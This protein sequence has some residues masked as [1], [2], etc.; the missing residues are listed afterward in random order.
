MNLNTTQIL[1]YTSKLCKSREG[2]EVSQFIVEKPMLETWVLL[3]M[4][5]EP[6]DGVDTSS[7]RKCVQNTP[8]ELHFKRENL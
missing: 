1:K 6:L 2:S 4:T 8:R 7:K 5:H 3:S